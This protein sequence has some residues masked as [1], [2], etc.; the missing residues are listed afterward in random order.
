ML[1]KHPLCADSALFLD[2]NWA[3]TSHREPSR[4]QE[5]ILR[6]YSRLISSTSQCLHPG[7]TNP[8]HFANDPLA[9]LIPLRL[10]MGPTEV[11][12]GEVRIPGNEVFE[13][14]FLPTC[15]LQ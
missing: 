8:F 11:R 4:S 14:G 6:A 15:A 12:M 1:I 5:G 2:W 7:F 3:E 9:M 13:L 10:Q